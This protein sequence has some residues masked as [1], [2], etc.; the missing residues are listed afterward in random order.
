MI[1]AQKADLILTVVR[2]WVADKKP[3]AS[4]Q[5][6]ETPPE[7]FSSIKQFDHL[8]IINDALHRSWDIVDKSITQLVCRVIEYYYYTEPEQT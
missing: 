2:K 7:L 8:S 6:V 3:P 1:A 5:I 4:I